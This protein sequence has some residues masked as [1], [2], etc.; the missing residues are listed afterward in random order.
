M[1]GAYPD[2]PSRRL[3]W[4]ETAPA[5][6]EALDTPG[7]QGKSVG[8]VP[9]VPYTL[10]GQSDIDKLNREGF[11]LSTTTVRRT[12]NNH[13]A[14][15]ILMFE[16]AKDI[17]GGFA[18]MTVDA[19]RT[20]WI[21]YSTNTTQGLD[22][23]WTTLGITTTHGSP[24]EFAA[25]PGDGYRDL[26]SSVAVSGVRSLMIYG[27]A[28]DVIEWWTYH[29]YGVP[30]AGETPDRLL[31]LDPDDSDNEFTKPLDYGDIERG[32][33]FDDTFKVR[34]NSSSLSA[35]TVQLTGQDLFGGA[36]GWLTYSD[37]GSFQATLSI[38]NLA[39]STTYGST[40][41]VRN[42]VPTGTV[43]GTY[44]ARTRITAASWT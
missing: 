3:A 2:N 38:G 41:T 8:T 5:V 31:F 32:E 27:G 24:G 39:S 1:A 29:F 6:F 40:I 28:D 35:N 19:E 20:H 9:T 7:G 11:V 4:D 17:D 30:D 34:N 43:L 16:E 14:W 25:P 22:G 21:A 26:I 18:W 13:G 12:G 44:V 36:G 42:I 23:T 33:T 10:M 15:I 37:G